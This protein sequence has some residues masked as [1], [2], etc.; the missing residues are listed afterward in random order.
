MLI[1][2]KTKP[3]VSV[4]RPKEPVTRSSTYLKVMLAAST[5]GA[6]IAFYYLVS[7]ILQYK[8]FTSSIGKDGSTFT[9]DTSSSDYFSLIIIPTIVLAAFVYIF[10][11][12]AIFVMKTVKSF[13]DIS[14]LLIYPAILTLLVILLTQFITGTVTKEKQL[15]LEKQIGSSEFQVIHPSQ[16]SNESDKSKTS[17]ATKTNKFFEVVETESSGKVTLILNEMSESPELVEKNDKLYFK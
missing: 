14:F 11:M 12:I 3:S 10:I 5:A 4:P 1:I 13:Q 17:Y 8:L 6:V 16:G 2:S 7:G 15:W 9:Y